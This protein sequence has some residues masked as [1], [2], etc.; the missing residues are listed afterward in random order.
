M[1]SPQILYHIYI[2]VTPQFRI[3]GYNVTVIT[4]KKCSAEKCADIQSKGAELKIA[5]TM[6]DLGERFIA[7]MDARQHGRLNLS[8][9]SR[10]AVNEHARW[11]L[12]L[13][14][15]EWSAA[16]VSDA[17]ACIVTVDLVQDHG[18]SASKVGKATKDYMEIESIMA[19][20]VSDVTGEKLFF[21][22]DQYGNQSN[23]N[24]HD[25][26]LG[27]EIWAYDCNSSREA[28]EQ[29]G[30]KTRRVTDF[31]MVSSTGGTVTGVAH[32]LRRLAEE[33]RKKSGS[34]DDG[35]VYGR[36]P[37]T[38]LADPK[39]SNMRFCVEPGFDQPA[40]DEDA[41]WGVSGG[42]GAILVEGAGKGSSTPLFERNKSF[43]Y[44]GTNCTEFAT[45]DAEEATL[46]KR[47][48]ATVVPDEEA[49]SMMHQLK[50]LHN[51][52]SGSSAGTNIVAACKHADDLAS[53]G[54]ANRN[55][56]TIL[57]DPFHKYA[58]KFADDAS[59]EQM[60]LPLYSQSLEKFPV[61]VPT[62]VR[63][64]DGSKVLSENGWDIERQR[65]LN[66]ARK[67]ATD[68]KLADDPAGTA[69]T[70]V[71]GGSSCDV[72][73]LFELQER[74]GDFHEQQQ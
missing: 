47:G 30:E 14:S 74:M 35:G 8:T 9:L 68:Y 64:F 72:A 67:H 49:I 15:D 5:E 36:F 19:S 18:F 7:S 37:L 65:Q 52:P 3:E 11:I 39:G 71:M 10:E 60:G 66:G 57:C 26:S 31:I 21:S 38:V 69:G 62:I 55:I 24:S 2:I 51:M 50:L 43:A 41:V 54:L 61:P 53:K 44:M 29:G 16:D 73:S 20:L 70:E 40:A 48:A 58:S 6:K 32:S 28:S 23:F 1:V 34:A 46:V 56:F 45:H 17:Q 13:K 33:Q 25:S 42:G 27:P 12:A 59:L 22:I 4:N 63:S